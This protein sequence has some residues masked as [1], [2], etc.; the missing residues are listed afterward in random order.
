MAVAASVLPWLPTCLPLAVRLS[1]APWV[2]A[3]SEP[4]QSL[5]L[6][7]EQNAPTG[8]QRMCMYWLIS[9]HSLCIYTIRAFVVRLQL[10]LCL[11]LCPWLRARSATI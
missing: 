9:A 5:E 1:I 2:M 7:Q 10:G 11:R 6:A 3:G 8:L 4:T